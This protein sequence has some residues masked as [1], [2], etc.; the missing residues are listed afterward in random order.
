MLGRA[1]DSFPRLFAHAST[2]TAPSLLATGWKKQLSK[3]LACPVGRQRRV[4]AASPSS[5]SL[6]GVYVPSRSLLRTCPG[7]YRCYR[8]CKT[9]RRDWFDRPLLP[10][11]NSPSQIHLGQL[12]TSW[13]TYRQPRAKPLDSLSLGCF[14]AIQ[15]D[16]RNVTARGSGGWSHPHG[17]PQHHP[18]DGIRLGKS[19]LE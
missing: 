11:A 18:C 19:W 6:H 12:G 7:T 3:L 13:V 17:L 9:F 1:I 8:H 16:S 10:F 14:N 2:K 5:T 4:W 15:R